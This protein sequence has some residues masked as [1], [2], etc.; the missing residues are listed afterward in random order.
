MSRSW[1]D[2]N[3]VNVVR[4]AFV[5]LEQALRGAGKVPAAD[6]VTA[7]PLVNRL[8]SSGSADRIDLP[9]E[10]RSGGELEGIHQLFLGAFQ[11]FR[12]PA[13]HRFI[14]YKADNADEIIRLVDLCLR[15]LETGEAPPLEVR[16]RRDADV[17]DA[18]RSLEEIA[19]RYPGNSV[20][21][22]GVDEEL[23]DEP[24]RPLRTRV[25]ITE[26]LRDEMVAQEGV[27]IVGS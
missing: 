16:L 12:N 20:V 6:S 15:I 14:D 5:F 27:K 2:R 9:G 8:L 4:D 3:Y 7:V 19:G 22:V 21:L 10:A 25:D 24:L 11:V 18:L 23:P 17:D 26:T 1:N 13:A